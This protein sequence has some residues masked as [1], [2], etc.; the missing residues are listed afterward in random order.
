MPVADAFIFRRNKNMNAAFLSSM[1]NFSIYI[2]IYSDHMQLLIH[3]YQQVFSYIMVV[4]AR[5]TS[6][7]KRLSV[8]QISTRPN[9]RVFIR[10]LQDLAWLPW[11]AFCLLVSTCDHPRTRI[12]PHALLTNENMSWPHRLVTSYVFHHTSSHKIHLQ[13]KQRAF[14]I[15][16]IDGTSKKISKIDP[17]ER[18]YDE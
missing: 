18:N 5:L 3:I 16:S 4:C 6:L 2:N 13:F 1:Y 14:F 8:P 7:T 17:K 12:S 10:V 11:C 15:N 9:R